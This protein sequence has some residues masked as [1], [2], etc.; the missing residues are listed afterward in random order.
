MSSSNNNKRD[1][2]GAIKVSRTEDMADSDNPVH[3]LRTGVLRTAE[4]EQVQF[5]R[6]L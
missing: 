4:I 6:Q 1:L 2:T 5:W 3:D